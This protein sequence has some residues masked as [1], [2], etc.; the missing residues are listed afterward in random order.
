MDARQIEWLQDTQEMSRD[1]FLN[2][3]EFGNE[4]G[5]NNT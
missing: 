3:N 5:D 1:N 4:P 2:I